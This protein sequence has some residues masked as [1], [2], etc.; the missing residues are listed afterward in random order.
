MI[1]QKKQ[2]TPH[3][4][5]K[6]L[7][8][9]CG[10]GLCNVTSEL[11]DLAEKV[12]SILGNVPMYP[13]SGS[14]C[15]SHNKKVGG[16]PTSK[17]LSGRALDFYVTEM[18]VY[19]AYTKIEAAQKRGDLPELGGLGFYPTKNFIHIDTYHAPDGHLRKWRG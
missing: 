16:S 8:C 15:Y 11:G 6:E 14:R 4:S 5:R 17:H 18:S 10:C 19:C 7:E 2:I 9:R 3:F 13:T 1:A 12:R